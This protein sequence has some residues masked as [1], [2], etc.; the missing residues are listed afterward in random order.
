MG[1]K[2]LSLT[3]RQQLS[4]AKILYFSVFLCLW[5]IILLFTPYTYHLDEIKVSMTFTFGPWLLFLFL[6]LSL[7]PG[8]NILPR[9]VVIPLLSYIGIMIVSTILS[10]FKWIGFIDTGLQIALTGFFVAVAG[11][12]INQ[13]LVIKTVRIFILIGLVTTI[14]G[15]LQYA[16]L[17][18]LIEKWFYP[19]PIATPFDYM[20]ILVHTFANARE[21]FSTI[22]NRDFYSGFLVMLLPITLAGIIVLEQPKWRLLSAVVLILEGSCLYLAF[23]KDSFA[24]AIIVIAVFMILYKVFIHYKKLYIPH[25]QIWLVGTLIIAGTLFFFT[26]QIVFDKLKGMDRS[27]ASRSIIWSGSV[28]QFLLNP[29]IGTGP[30]TFR[31]YFPKF[32]RDDY[33]EHDISN[34]TLYSHNRYLDLLCET[35]VLGFAT[36]MWFTF[37]I[38][39]LGIRQIIYG[40]DPILRVIQ[41]GLFASIIGLLFT[42]FFSPSVR[43]VVIGTTY[44]ALVGISLGCALIEK[45]QGSNPSSTDNVFKWKR[46]KILSM[47]MVITAI[48]A[49][50]STVYAVRYFIGAYYHNVGLQYMNFETNKAAMAEAARNFDLSIKY[51]PFFLSSYYKQGHVVSVLGKFDEAL[52][53]YRRL[54]KLAPDYAEI[55]YNLGVLLIRDGKW[56]EALEEMKEAARQS[57][58]DQTRLMAG[59]VFFRNGRLEEA[60]KYYLDVLSVDPK[61][62]SAKY[63]L[64]QACRLLKQTKEAE[65]YLLELY[66]EHPEEETFINEL[67][68]LYRRE[69]KLVELENFMNRVVNDNPLSSKVRM[70]LLE[71]LYEQGKITEA[72][73]HGI[74]LDKLNF[75]EQKFYYLMAR[76]YEQLG[77][78]GKMQEFL[79]KTLAKDNNTSE[80]KTAAELLMQFLP[81]STK[82]GP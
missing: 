52:A 20:R 43:W 37:M 63:N 41:L 11:S 1:Q 50:A 6:Y 34:V 23:S 40:K 69:N 59:D 7:K 3:Q 16:G 19:V 26:R 29:I 28:Q 53:T 35:G 17:F 77:E 80:G 74:V 39:Y 8:L 47:L 32:R 70:L 42:N 14:F 51:N 27:F 48:I 66:K 55:H 56:E 62:K 68:S 33:F 15:L 9:S 24:A 38:L 65:K 5:L 46:A 78:S 22:L 30:G 2:R 57:R 21:M 58:K 45:Q 72:L 82:K 25:W 4:R 61:N 71:L 13:E 73:K 31:I 10:A 18:V 12:L 81:E 36:Y 76:I 44:W 54:Q 49:L 60:Q 64:A 79:L 67:I 75:S